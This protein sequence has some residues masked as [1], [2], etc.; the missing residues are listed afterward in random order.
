MNEFLA[1]KF[2]ITF[3]FFTSGFVW[4][5]IFMRTFVMLMLVPFLAGKGVAGRFRLI[6]AA[7]LST[8]IFVLMGAQAEATLPHDKAMI[9]ALF[10][11]EFFFGLA[12]GMTTLMCFYAIEAGGR[13]VDNQRGSANA[14]IFLPQLGQVSIFGLFQFQLALT[15]FL[16]FSGHIPFLRAYVE[17]FT[18]L[19]V[20]TLPRMA[21][22]FSPFLELMIRMSADV[23]LWGMQ[24]ASPVL[25]AIFLT[26][27]VLGIANKMAPQIPVFDL[28]F[29]LKGYVG[30]GMVYV[31]ILSV[32]SQMDVFF[33]IMN[34]NVQKVI[35]LFAQ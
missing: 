15:L 35:L 4:A 14:Q 3:D 9:A 16:T 13:I 22:G 29:L 11:K 2:G 7:I 30:V 19:P 18:T 1:Q 32:I 8:F 27:L 23:L 25:I 10:A 5:L 33:K 17:S 6:L 24:L 20:T 12:I 26:D 28:G 31:S 34:D 21:P